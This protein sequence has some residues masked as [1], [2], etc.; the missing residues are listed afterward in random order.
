[1]QRFEIRGALFSLSILVAGLTAQAVPQASAQGVEGVLDRS[2]NGS[3]FVQLNRYPGYENNSDLLIQPDGKILAGG[4]NWVANSG[5]FLVSRWQSNGELDPTFGTNGSA[6]LDITEG[7]ARLTDDGDYLEAMALQPDGRILLAGRSGVR[8]RQNDCWITVVRLMPDG[9]LDSTFGSNGI[10]LIDT[11]G[12]INGGGGTAKDIYVAADGRILLLL[13]NG[14]LWLLTD[15]SLDSSFGTGGV[16]Q[17]PEVPNRYLKATAISVNTSRDVWVTGESCASSVIDVDRQCELLVVKFQASGQVD[18]RFG[19]EGVFSADVGD[20]HDRGKAIAHT[21]EGHTV[22]GGE[23]C[24]L[25]DIG[26]LSCNSLVVKLLP[27]GELDR[28]FGQSGTLVIPATPDRYNS[29]SYVSDI[30]LLNNE[31]PV[32]AVVDGG[33]P[34]GKLIRLTKTGQLDTAFG[35]GGVAPLPTEEVP[36]GF[37]FAPFALALQSDGKLVVSGMGRLGA[38]DDRNYNT[39]VARFTSS[40]T[41]APLPRPTASP[42]RTFGPNRYE[43]AVRLSE[44]FFQ[45]GTQELFIA[46]GASFAD[47]LA[48][49]PIAGARGAPVLLTQSTGMSEQL[50]QE[51]QRLNPKKIYFVGGTSAI[52]GQVENQV[53]D[54]GYPVTRIF[55]TDRF[56]T[57]TAL[58]KD[59]F[60]SGSSSVFVVSGESYADAVSAG[61]A[62]GVLGAPLLLVGRNLLPS[63]TRDELQRLN[64]EKIYVV[65]GISA[66]SQEILEALKEYSDDVQRIAGDDRY[67][68]SALVSQRFFSAGSP[69]SFLVTGQD[70]PDALV[71]GSIASA[72]S[73]PVL[74]SKRLCLP[75]S[76][77][78]ELNR[79]SPDTI[80]VVGGSN[81]LSSEIDQ[82]KYCE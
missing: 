58:S 1:M 27:G 72:S 49:G 33:A 54:L 14:L 41:S 55:G 52:G 3:G 8:C 5:D 53:K 39:V 6:K 51:I 67:Q 76:I 35:S 25:S 37:P 4:T 45:S 42:T 60:A 63:A 68:T 79:V 31:K 70:F 47:A 59:Q 46:T 28:S 30:L 71:A 81:S 74:L 77:L 19:T 62:A 9:Q 10:A 34:S 50:V 43:T 29:P 57:A 66:I 24:N 2:F 12:E 44:E 18:T 11:N 23:A 22:V 36:D 7:E 15:G 82:Y 21:R 56:E 75:P 13:E 38:N 32:I 64:P 48:A 40:P 69:R 80:H 17:L 61:P 16:S 20:Y 26:V 73:S 78:L 65:G